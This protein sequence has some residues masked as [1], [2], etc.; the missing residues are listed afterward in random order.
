MIDEENNCIK[1]RCKVTTEELNK[2][3]AVSLNQTKIYLPVFNGYKALNANCLSSA[4]YTKFHSEDEIGPLGINSTSG[5]LEI[6]R[7]EKSTYSENKDE[8]DMEKNT[9]SKLSA[10]NVYEIEVEYPLEAYKNLDSNVIDL[11]FIAETKYL[12]HN[13]NMVSNNRGYEWSESANKNIEVVY[14]NIEKT[15]KSDIG[16]EIGKNGVSTK[17]IIDSYRGKVSEDN[18]MNYLVKVYFLFIMLL[19]FYN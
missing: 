14:E 9:I 15:D 6:Y 1:L 4:D 18:V 19:F 5:Y 8:F 10:I 11:E 2:Q 16:I 3:L 12:G 17:D 13:P 7:F